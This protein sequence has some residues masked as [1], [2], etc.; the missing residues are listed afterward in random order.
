MRG[1]PR[2]LGLP[3]SLRLALR[4]IRGPFVAGIRAVAAATLAAGML[5]LGDAITL[6]FGVALTWRAFGR[7]SVEMLRGDL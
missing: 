5:V 3:L 7:A 4:E 6:A 1:R 2:P